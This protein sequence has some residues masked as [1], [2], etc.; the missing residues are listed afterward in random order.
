MRRVINPAWS[1]NIELSTISRIESTDAAIVVNIAIGGRRTSVVDVD[2]GPARDV[3]TFFCAAPMESQSDVKSDV[4]AD[5]DTS[6]QLDERQVTIIM[7]LAQVCALYDPT[8]KTFVVNVRGFCGRL[9]E[10]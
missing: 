4:N 5:S 2:V 7:L 9:F 8:P 3:S 10:G 1:I 6:H